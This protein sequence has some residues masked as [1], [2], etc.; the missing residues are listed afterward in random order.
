MGRITPEPIPRLEKTRL[1]AMQSDILPGCAIHA[2]AINTESLPRSSRLSSKNRAV[3]APSVIPEKRLML[4][5]GIQISRCVTCCAE[6]VIRHLDY[7]ANALQL[8]T[9][10]QSTLKNGKHVPKRD[11]AAYDAVKRQ[12][13][14]RD[15]WRCRH[16]HSRSN[17]T[18]HHIVLRSRC[19]EDVLENLL[20]LCVRCHNA[21]HDGFLTIEW[22]ALGGNGPVQF[23]RKKGYKIL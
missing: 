9:V 21:I 19:G 2:Y 4:T 18:P 8:F 23:T 11:W 10:Q 7:Y 1:A 12:M 6:P 5:I 13:F 17:L 15:G 3:C 16:C 14:I 20:C 22:G